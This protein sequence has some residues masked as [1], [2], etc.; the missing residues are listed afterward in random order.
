MMS[1]EIRTSLNIVPL[2]R[3]WI[4]CDDNPRRSSICSGGCTGVSGEFTL[5]VA[6]V[7]S[8]LHMAVSL[9][10]WRDVFVAIVMDVILV[11][12]SS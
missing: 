7:E 12:G 8:A 6:S 1:R 5:A 11:E 10:L 9:I 4:H 3:S 2:G